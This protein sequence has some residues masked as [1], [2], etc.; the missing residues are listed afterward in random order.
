[1]PTVSSSSVDDGGVNVA[2]PAVPHCNHKASYG[3]RKLAAQARTRLRKRILDSTGTTQPLEIYHCYFPGHKWHI[4]HRSGWNA[5]V[6]KK[7]GR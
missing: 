7:Y 5:P 1:M 2:P 6:Q 3:N 4:G